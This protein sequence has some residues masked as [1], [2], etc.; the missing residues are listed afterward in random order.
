MF[1]TNDNF[2]TRH[3]TLENWIGN[4]NYLVLRAQ[5]EIFTDFLYFS[6]NFLLISMYPGAQV[7]AQRSG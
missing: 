4:H 1:K 6:F 3:E 5:R 7:G 2:K